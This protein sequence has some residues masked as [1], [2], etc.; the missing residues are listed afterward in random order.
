MSKRLVR[1]DV[2]LKKPATLKCL[3]CIDKNK[4]NPKLC[5]ACDYLQHV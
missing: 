3:D 4:S 2:C 5:Y 1:C